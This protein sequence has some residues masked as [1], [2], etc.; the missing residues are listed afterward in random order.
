MNYHIEHHM[1]ARVPCYNLEKLHNYVKHDLPPT[2]PP[3]PLSPTTLPGRVLHCWIRWRWWRCPS[4]LCLSLTRYRGVWLGLPC[5]QMASSKPGPKSS[6][7]SRGKSSTPTTPCR[8]FCPRCCPAATACLHTEVAAVRCCSPT[9]PVRCCPP[10][11]RRTG[12]V[13]DALQATR[14]EAL[15]KVEAA[16]RD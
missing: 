4:S 3:H 14:S 5:S 8:S 12:D 15:G 16:G 1:Y 2:V 6:G 7:S 10:T 9:L 13:R 11:L